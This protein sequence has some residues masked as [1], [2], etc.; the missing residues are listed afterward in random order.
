M[1]ED[2]A[3]TAA[4]CVW[5]EC[6]RSK[7]QVRHSWSARDVVIHA[8]DS[9]AQHWD[10]EFGF[11]IHDPNDVRELARWICQHLESANKIQGR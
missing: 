2:E 3:L 8:V 4:Q 5:L 7:A 11:G 6:D 1:S 10:L 9:F